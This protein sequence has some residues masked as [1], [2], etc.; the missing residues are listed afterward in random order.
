MEH[1]PLAG[2][3]VLDFSWVWAGPFCTMQ[4]AHMGAEVIR[5]E[6]AARLCTSRRIPPFADDVAGINRAGYYNQYNQGKRSITLNLRHPQGLAIAH[7]LVGLCDVVTENFAAG[8]IERLGLGY[9]TLRKM[10]PD[11]IMLS[12]SGFGRTGPYRAVAGYGPAVSALS[13]FVSAT[14]Y[15][16]YAPQLL[17]ISYADPSTG[18]LAAA[19]IVAALINRDRTGRGMYIDQSL[20]EPSLALMAEGLVEYAMTGREPARIGNRDPLLVPHNCYKARGDVNQWVTIAVATEHEWRS[21][22]RVMGDEQLAQDPR[23]DSAAKRKRNEDALDEIITAWT[24]AHD[25]WDITRR[26][27]EAGVC[28]FPS[29]SNKDL[30]HD[31]HLQARGFLVTKEHPEVGRRIHAGIPWTING[32]PVDVSGAAP[33][34]GADTDAILTELLGLKPDQIER[35]RSQGVLE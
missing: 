35:L 1:L 28:A 10:R 6:S 33:I 22:C 15:E 17:G 23:F 25:R 12:I 7:G 13:G 14:G 19:A 8:V 11:L 29:M 30:A 34:L 18:V 16:G 21:L 26:L 32:A 4:L 27:Q 2:V 5:V 3:R 9:E 24:S 31:P 20:L